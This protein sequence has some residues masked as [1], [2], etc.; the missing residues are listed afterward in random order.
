M[1]VI[2]KTNTNTKSEFA[3]KMNTASRASAECTCHCGV[4]S[5]SKRCVQCNFCAK[6]VRREATEWS[7]KGSWPLV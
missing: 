3:V 5:T 6:R 2:Q 7:D 1:C 4:G